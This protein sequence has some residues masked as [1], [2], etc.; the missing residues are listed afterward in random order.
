M[1]IYLHIIAAA[2][3]TLTCMCCT[4][5]SYIG[6][7]TC[8][9]SGDAII[10]DNQRKWDT[11]RLVDFYKYTDSEPTTV[12]LEEH[13]TGYIQSYEG[14]WDITYETN[15]KNQSNVILIDRLMVVDGVDQILMTMEDVDSK[16]TE[17]IFRFDFHGEFTTLLCRMHSHKEYKSIIHH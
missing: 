3:F 5:Q 14:R 12:F 9:A 13:G 10:L 7:W 1:R 15:Y 17:M 16:G 4:S 2:L 6:R 11:I 8:D